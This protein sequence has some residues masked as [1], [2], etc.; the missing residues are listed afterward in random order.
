MNMTEM[1]A[2]KN[3]KINLREVLKKYSY[4]W[5]LLLLGIIIALTCAFLYLRFATYEYQVS[6]TILINDKD[7]DSGSELSV[8]QDLGLFAGSKT[9]IETEKGVLKSKT[10]IE[11][12]VRDLGANI[13]YYIKNDI[14]FKEVYKDDIPFNINFFANE[15]ILN[16]L[17]TSFSII[18]KS[19]TKFVLTDSKGNPIKEGSFG[20][21]VTGEFGELVITPIAIDN[22]ELGKEI[23][24]KIS[25]LEEV[26]IAFKQRIKITVDNLKSNLLIIKLQDP[27]KLKARKI[28]DSLVSYYN[29]DAVEYKSQIT[30][31]TDKFIN[32]RIDD[33]SIELT[34][35]DQ[36]VET[37]KIENKLS[38]MD[39]EADLVLASNATLTKQIVELTSQIKLIDYVA[40]YMKTNKDDLIPGNL[41]ILNE[42]TSQNTL[43]YN[44]LLL[45]RNRLLKGANKENPIIINLNDQITSLRESIDR[46]LVNTRSSLA[47]SLNEAKLQEYKLNSKISATPKKEREIK[48]IQRQQQIIETLYLYLLQKREENS[49][50]L[51][52][53]AKYAK[54]IDKAYGSSVP[55]APRK[56]IVL[57]ASLLL[58]I[59]IPTLFIIVKSLFDNRIHA[60]EDLEGII[61]AP[62]LGDIPSAKTKKS[63]ITFEQKRN[64][65]AA[66]S[67]RLLRTNV[68][69]ALSNIN[70][71]ANAVFITSTLRNEGKT[72]IAI[73]L[74]TAM[75]LLDKKVLLI[76]ADIRNPKIADYLKLKKE[77]GLTD[78]LTDPSLK[79][80]DV[81][82]HNERTKLDIVEA[83]AIA[84]SP[85]E[86]LSNGR[87]ETL[88]A[89]AKNN[90]D[91]VIVDTAPVNI[92][93]DTLLLGHQADLFVY[94]VRAK[95][96]D[97][98]ML[99]IPKK[100]LENKRLANMNI[101]M[102]DTNYE[103]RGYDSGYNYGETGAKKPWWIRIFR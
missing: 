23:L 6:S 98:R 65:T 91:Y 78:F 7:N 61:D 22:I 5:K 11:R 99:N 71:D 88:L 59:L 60:I 36:G 74:A 68:S 97:K 76:E 15:S 25:P 54:I 57:I 38:N 47:I 31:N 33:I 53:S 13:T 8:F 94:V 72:F 96:L 90:Y 20:E 69:H 50:S 86:F 66:E 82:K 17:N 81:I 70:K 89:Y 43:K 2:S 87:F 40:K 4:H 49:I 58:G 46:S 73:N 84:K 32:N 64:N 9:S 85:S 92:A 34:S 56:M 30:R 62:V 37:Y 29:R 48:D 75:A 14:A 102:N 41:G 18:T 19:A 51:A 55:V 42:A 35:L 93:T 16:K 39:S 79:E 1:D 83:G 44:N 63:I 28:L 67:F 45:D 26:A 80:L 101:L 100:I 27:V 95:F 77:K 21:R 12:V 10:L 52:V 3:D 24:I 103:K